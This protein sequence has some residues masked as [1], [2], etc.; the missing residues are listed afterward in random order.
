M[1]TVT[2]SPKFPVVIRKRIR[3]KLGLHAGQQRRVGGAS[4]VPRRS[5]TPW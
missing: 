4:Q 2:I 5:A 3:E 1:E